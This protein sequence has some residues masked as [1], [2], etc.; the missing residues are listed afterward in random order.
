MRLPLAFPALLILLIP[1]RAQ[2]TLT[3]QTSLTGFSSSISLL[4]IN[5][6]SLPLSSSG[7]FSLDGGLVNLFINTPGGAVNFTSPDGQ[8]ITGTT[9]TG[10]GIVQGAASGVYAPPVT[11]SSGST[12]SGNYISTGLGDIVLTFSQPVFGFALL[13]G[14][15]D[16]TNELDIFSNG[17][18][19]SNAPVLGTLVGTVLGSAIAPGATGSQTFGGSFYTSITSTVAFDQVYLTSGAVSFE[20]ADFNLEEP[21]P[22]TLLSGLA[23]LILIVVLRR[24]R[25][26][27]A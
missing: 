15:V 19:K 8:H 14:S 4:S 5:F 23:G 12:W 13:W 2:A 20:S 9:P 22:G 1:F 25:T 11:N 3:A 10:E 16:P 17:S 24:S 27:R 26:L 6:S 21:E 7:D 18:V